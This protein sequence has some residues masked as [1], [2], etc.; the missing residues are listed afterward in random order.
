M[1]DVPSISPGIHDILDFWFLPLGHPDHAKAREIW[2]R[3]TPDFDAETV[4]RFGARIEQAVAGELD[5]WKDL[6]EGALA[7]ILLC[8]QFPRNCFRKTA[9]AFSGDAKALETAR[10]ALARFY[11]AAFAPNLRLFF[12]MPF[13]H[14]EAL[15]DQHLACALFDTIGGEENLKSAAAHRDVVARFGRF[16]HRNEVLG[17]ATTAEEFD[18]LRDAKRYGQ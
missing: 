3:S 9:R 15:A 8:D 12:Y 11:P 7:L 16:P 2:W 4:S 13:G 10:L 18:Y 6:P 14:S 5:A 17:R 1:T